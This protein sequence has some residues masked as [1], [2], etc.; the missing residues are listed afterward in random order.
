MSSFFT[1]NNGYRIDAASAP[2][3]MIFAGLFDMLSLIPFVNVFSSIIGHTLLVLFFRMRGV[4]IFSKRLT[5]IAVTAIVVEVVPI[6]SILPMFIV[7]T[8]IIIHLSRKEDK[9]N[10]E[11]E[12]TAS[13]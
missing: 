8:A 3:L 9:K 5:A 6:L 11:K 4:N 1:K 2:T 10:M 7:G 12:A 13:Q